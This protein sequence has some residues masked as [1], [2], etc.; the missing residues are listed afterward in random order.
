MRIGRPP[1]N[2]GEC[3]VPDCTNHARC[4]GYCNTHYRRVLSHG[5]PNVVLKRGQKHKIRGV[6]LADECESRE[7]ASG[8]CSPHYRRLRKYGDPLCGGTMVGEPMKWIRN[9]AT[10]EGSDCLPW[11]F[12]DGEGY[13]SLSLG[14]GK[15]TN[16]HRQMC[17][18]AHGA[19]RKGQIVRHI[20]GNKICVN[21]QHLAWGTHAENSA[22]MV[23]HGTRLVGVDHK[24]SKV[25]ESDVLEM[26]RRRACGEELG[27]IASDYPVGK[28]C[29]WAIVTCATWKHVK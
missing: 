3:S 26:R 14:N 19:P 20:C 18:V 11:P 13:F 15:W 4:K 7:F 2:V 28:A 29:V 22:D 1:I 21:P 6:C 23:I 12:S 24:T 17:K 10:H 5:D 9:N 25:T 27:S 8:Y 16:A